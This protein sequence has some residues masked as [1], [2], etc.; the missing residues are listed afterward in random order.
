MLC[1]FA[2]MANLLEREREILGHSAT[3]SLTAGDRRAVSI[4]HKVNLS[5]GGSMNMHE[6][7]KRLG[8]EK[9]VGHDRFPIHTMKKGDV[10]VS[11]RF[12]E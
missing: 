4:L 7:K 8:I 3:T 1:D 12:H 2:A 10:W 9:G 6:L 11:D 5:V